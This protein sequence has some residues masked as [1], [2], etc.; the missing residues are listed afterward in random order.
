MSTSQIKKLVKD[1]MALLVNRIDESNLTR[2]LEENLIIFDEQSNEASNQ[3]EY[4]Q[5]FR[6][7]KDIESPDLKSRKRWRRYTKSQKYELNSVLD[8]YPSYHSVIRKALQISI[9]SFQ[10]LKKE[11]DVDGLNIS[12]N[13]SDGKERRSVNDEERIY[14]QRLL[15]PPA[16]PITI[17]EI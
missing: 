3:R 8:K 17:Q 12:E 14:I 15:K 5:N 11:L 16:F 1:E 9:S 10:K 2:N 13:F 4:S 6:L 7:F